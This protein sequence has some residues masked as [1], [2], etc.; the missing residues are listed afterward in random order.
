MTEPRQNTFDALLVSFQGSRALVRQDNGEEVQCKMR[1]AARDTVS[2]DRVVVQIAGDEPVIESRLARSSEF[3]RTDMRGRKKMI[4]ANLDCLAIVVAAEPEPHLGLIDRY[5][6]GAELCG[7]RAEIV[8]NKADLPNQPVL[9]EIKRI[10]PK[11]G[12]QVTPVSAKHGDNLN[13]LVAWAKGKK[14]AFLGQSGVGKS[15]LI[16]A[17]TDSTSAA[18]GELSAKRTKGR[19]TTTSSYIYDMP[20]GGWIMD[21]PGIRDFEN[22]EWH[23]EDVIRG[24]PELYEASLNCQ[25]RNCQHL[26]DKG[27]AVTKGLNEGAIEESRYQSYLNIISNA[28]A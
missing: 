18:V 12:H 20:F 17:L 23:A 13:A 11:I 27:C 22:A 15:S 1:Q 28:S 5:L 6:L 14:L 7:L 21:S 19:H 24:F 2:G 25:F 26:N 4:A 10:Y 8:I 16:N 9:D 3:F